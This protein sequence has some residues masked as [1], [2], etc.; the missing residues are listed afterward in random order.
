MREKQSV[1]KGST[2]PLR[3]AMKRV[4]QQRDTVSVPMATG[5]DTVTTVS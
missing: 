1:W 2:V 4:L 3:T 5:E